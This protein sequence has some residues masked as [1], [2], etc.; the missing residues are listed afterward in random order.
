[1][2]K[3]TKTLLLITSSL[4]VFLTANSAWGYT[5]KLHFILQQPKKTW[6]QFVGLPNTVKGHCYDA[7]TTHRHLGV[8]YPTLKISHNGNKSNK[9]TIKLEH[10]HYACDVLSLNQ[11]LVVSVKDVMTGRTL[12]Q[13]TIPPAFC[14]GD[15]CQTRG[16]VVKT[17]GKLKQDHFLLKSHETKVTFKVK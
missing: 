4:L 3:F 6:V 17:S 2:L 16:Y 12:G 15:L 9:F 5:Y 8:K 11:T 1:M 14:T 10:N 7:H 13:I